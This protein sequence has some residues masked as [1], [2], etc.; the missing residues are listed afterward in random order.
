MKRILQ[1]V[2]WMLDPFVW[3][4]SLI[5]IGADGLSKDYR[6]DPAYK[7]NLQRLVKHH[8]QFEEAKE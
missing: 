8:R 1:F 2:E 6:E 3:I 5:G 4:A 7:K